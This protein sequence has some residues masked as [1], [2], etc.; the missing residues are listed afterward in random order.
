MD[1]IILEFTAYQYVRYFSGRDRHW[2][3]EAI[4]KTIGYKGDRGCTTE[5]DT[6]L[7]LGEVEARHPVSITLEIPEP[8]MDRLFHHVGQTKTC[9][10]EDVVRFAIADRL[11]EE[12]MMDEIAA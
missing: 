11:L 5:N 12:E 4:A 1:S 7:T 10:L 2:V 6:F 9:S 3:R 8:M